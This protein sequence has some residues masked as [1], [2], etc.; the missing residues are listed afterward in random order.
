MQS[1]AREEYLVTQV[2]TATP[3]KLQLMLLDGALRFGRQAITFWSE[4][5]EEEGGEAVLRCQGIVTELICS[6]RPEHNRELC[7]RVA[8]V[9]MYIFRTLTEA[10]TRQD[11]TKLAD[12]LRVL[13]EERETWYQVCQL[14]L[15]NAPAA[16]TMTTS[17]TADATQAPVVAPETVIEQPTVEERPAASAPAAAHFVPYGPA[18]GSAPT[19]STSFEA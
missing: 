9:Y 11:Q 3:Q 18:Y 5:R 19:A 13:E 2:M 7:R 17:I 14:D 6:L 8:S 12:A 16:A 1:S 4:G 15:G 10:H